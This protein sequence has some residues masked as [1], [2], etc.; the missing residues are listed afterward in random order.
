MARP[1]SRAYRRQEQVRDAVKVVRILR[2]VDA[3]EAPRSAVGATAA[4]DKLRG[5]PIVGQVDGAMNTVKPPSH[6]SGR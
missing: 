6:L 5:I 3:L 4:G 2:E 1:L